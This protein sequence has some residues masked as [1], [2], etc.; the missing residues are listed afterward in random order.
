M[1]ANA[2]TR[3]EAMRVSTIELFFDLVFVFTITQVT[4]LVEHVE[5]VWELGHA[6]LV[7]T[8]IWWMFSA[9]A[10]LTNST[11]PGRRIR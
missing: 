6:F 2:E 11:P 10:W 5:T 9:Y 3:P 4:R 1:T 8:L 7:L